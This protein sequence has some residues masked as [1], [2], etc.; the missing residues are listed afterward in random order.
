[1]LKLLRLPYGRVLERKGG[2]GQNTSADTL[3]LGSTT[4][5]NVVTPYGYINRCQVRGL[6]AN[7]M[8]QE[9]V[10]TMGDQPPR[11]YQRD[12]EEL[13]AHGP[14]IAKL[15][16]AFGHIQKRIVDNES[17][18]SDTKTGT[19]GGLHT[20]TALDV[21]HTPVTTQPRTLMMLARNGAPL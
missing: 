2:V 4:C 11:F 9:A 21:L 19:K 18:G 17:L 14:V 15:Q 1:M 3:F 20:W 16:K 6:E 12:E 5:F 10:P 8:E 13:S 7:A